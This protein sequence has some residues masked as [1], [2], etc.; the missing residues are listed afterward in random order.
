M[1]TKGRINAQGR[2]VIPAAARE[3]A[4]LADG[5]EVLF[6]VMGKGELRLRSKGQAIARAQQIVGDAIAPHRNLA[7][8]LIAERRRDAEKE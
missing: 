5:D 4:G 1:S 8:E 3:A 6:E 7:D 2:I